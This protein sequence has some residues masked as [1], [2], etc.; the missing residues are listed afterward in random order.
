MLHRQRE[1]ELTLLADHLAAPLEESRILDADDLEVYQ[2]GN[3]FQRSAHTE[4]E[5]IG[6][7]HNP[8]SRGV[9][10]ATHWMINWDDHAEVNL[11]ERLCKNPSTPVPLLENIKHS[12]DVSYESRYMRGES[13][14]FT[15]S[16]SS[17]AM[18]EVV[19]LIIENP[20]MPARIIEGWLQT[21]MGILGP[22]YL[23]AALN[24]SAM[25]LWMLEHPDILNDM[26]SSMHWSVPAS[27]LLT[28]PGVHKILGPRIATLTYEDSDLRSLYSPSQIEIFQNDWVMV[29]ERTRLR[30]ASDWTLYRSLRDYASNRSNT[31]A[32][33]WI[34]NSDQYKHKQ[35]HLF[36]AHLNIE[37]K[38]SLQ[39][40]GIWL[41]E[42]R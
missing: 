28:Q 36:A 20:N 18:M 12:A 23:T 39:R 33:Y 9:P 32:E 35:L 4:S 22:R 30:G 24:N 10:N 25:L 14:R 15:R 38:L 40:N 29:Y 34:K 31:T 13:F 37:K 26:I 21:T 1:L 3:G 5:L 8:E 7:I 11:V 19:P 2:K 41:Q 17:H 16:A 27:M 42:K 6:F